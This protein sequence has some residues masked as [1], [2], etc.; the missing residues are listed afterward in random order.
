M[1]S[2]PYSA[3]GDEGYEV[4]LKTKHF[5]SIFLTPNKHCIDDNNFLRTIDYSFSFFFTK[6]KPF[7]FATQTLLSE[8]KNTLPG[9]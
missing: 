1:A 5:H 4:I 7:S 8:K 3:I 6:Q 9:Q 2:S